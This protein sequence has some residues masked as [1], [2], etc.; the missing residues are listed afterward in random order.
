MGV[1]RAFCGCRGVVGFNGCYSWVSSGDGGFMLACISGC[2]GVI[3]FKVGTWPCPVRE[4]VRPAWPCEGA[5][6]KKFAQ[7]TKNGSKSAFSG[8]LGE[9]FRG[10]AAGGGV[11]GEFFRGNAAGGG[12][13]GCN[14][15]AGSRRIPPHMTSG[16]PH[17]P[18]SHAVVFRTPAAQVVPALCA[19]LA[20]CCGGFGTEASRTPSA[21][22]SEIVG[23][24]TLAPTRAVNICCRSRPSE[25][26]RPAL[27]WLIDFVM[28]PTI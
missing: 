6:A 7:R 13:L 26:P 10:N 20:H 16:P 28:S 24:T 3:G 5:S 1:F 4:K 15:G 11:L 14:S 9:F 2:R 27:I 19:S 17:E 21:T 25:S 22:A 23:E 8:V 18:A 12:V